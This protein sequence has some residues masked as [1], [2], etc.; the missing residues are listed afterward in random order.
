MRKTTIAILFL[1]CSAA[2]SQ[3]QEITVT[4]SSVTAYSQGATSV[5][6]T[7]QNVKDKRPV[8]A[9]WCGEV[10]PATP[11][12]GFKCNEA[13]VFG[14]LPVRYTQLRRSANDSY[15]DVMS[16]PAAVAR[17][18]YTDAASGSE[19]TFFYVRRF[20]SERGGADEFLPVTIRLGGNGAAVAFSITNVK[21]LW[22]VGKPVLFVKPGEKLPQINA[23]I[24]YTGTGRLKGRWELVKPGEE[25]PAERDL[26]PDAQLPIEERSLQKRFVQLSRFNIYLAPGGKVVLPGP[27]TWKIESHLDGLYLVLLRIEATD[28]QTGDN[29]LGPRGPVAGFSLPALR[30]YVGSGNATQPINQT[31]IKPADQA[32]LRAEEVEFRWLEIDRA[33]LYRLEIEDSTSRKILIAYLQADTTVYKMPSWLKGKLADGRLQWRV[34]AFDRNRN[35]LSETPRR[36]LFLKD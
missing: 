1:L 23:E 33:E 3:A 14:C 27:E 17:R 31:N 10:V 20:V 6:L 4:P 35:P 16:I 36:Q 21:L 28:D 25:L 30:Y 8:D 12:L 22:G 32:T 7:F 11:H 18:A 9:C 24:T 15:T 5:L 26:L 2:A 34:I 29:S 19:A 13:T